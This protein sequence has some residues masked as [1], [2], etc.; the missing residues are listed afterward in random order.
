MP[1]VNKIHE[2]DCLVTLKTFP[3]NSIDAIVSDPPYGLGTHEPTGEEIDKYLSGESRLDT[4]GDF[5]GFSWDIPSVAIFKECLRVLK[6]GG[7]ILC[8]AGTRTFDLMASGMLAAGFI[9]EGG[10]AEKF[11]LPVLQWIH[12]QGFPKSMDIAKAIDKHLGVKR[13]VIGEQRIIKG[14]GSN[15]L[16]LHDG[17]RQEVQVPVTTATSPE[18][19]KWAG[20]GTALKPAWEPIICLRKPGPPSKLTPPAFSF[21]Y[22]PK[23]TASEADQGLDPSS[24]RKAGAS[25]DVNIDTVVDESSAAGEASDHA[26]IEKNS[27]P[28][29]KP[30]RIMEWLIGLASF[31]DD[32][33]LD[34]FCGSGTTCVAA[35]NLG[36]QYIGCELSPEFHKISVERVRRALSQSSASQRRHLKTAF[37]DT[38]IPDDLPPLVQEVLIEAAPV[39]EEPKP[40]PKAKVKP[41][42]K[43]KAKPEPKPE[44][45]VVVAPPPPPVKSE[46]SLFDLMMG[47]E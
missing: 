44:P 4:G 33:V 43:V 23:I 42:P 38:T 40:E 11:G 2:G 25:S 18:A 15:A 1:F 7:P 17:E 41:E 14:G 10:L 47:D 3:D 13:E 20:W 39:K 26:K 30:L 19:Q 28:T 32:I 6:P 12:G 29:R 24:Y 34:P 16:S 36:R 5:M 22:T 46:P 27:H 8:F 37:T 9:A 45:V 31:D 35:V 21:L